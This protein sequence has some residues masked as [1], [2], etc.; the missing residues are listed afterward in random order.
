MLCCSND[1]LTRSPTGVNCQE[2]GS[3]NYRSSEK[4]GCSILPPEHPHPKKRIFRPPVGLSALEKTNGTGP[5]LAN[6]AISGSFGYASHCSNRARWNGFS[7]P[8]PPD[9]A[10]AALREAR[11]LR[12]L[13]SRARRHLGANAD[14]RLRVRRDTQSLASASLAG[15]GW[16]PPTGSIGSTIGSI[17]PRTKRSWKR[18]AAA[19]SEVDRTA[20]PNGRSGSPNVS[21]WNR[22]TAPRAA[23]PK[24][25]V[26]RRG[27]VPRFKG[28]S[29]TTYPANIG[30]VPFFLPKKRDKLKN[31]T[32]PILT[33]WVRFGSF[34]YASHCS[35]RARWNG[36][37]CPKPR[38]RADAAF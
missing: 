16:R 8:E 3:A 22:R 14:A 5:I 27:P 19:C 36:F 24:R 6:W 30:P 20:R 9:R 35:N 26:A 25:D 4:R 11:R 29:Q 31:G 18:S 38:D 7:C 10:D 15:G 13:R 1:K 32:G 33:N 2:D 21:G 37:S 17:G 28:R 12:G 34:G 23:R